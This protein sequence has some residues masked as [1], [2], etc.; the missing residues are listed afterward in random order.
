MLEQVLKSLQTLPHRLT[1]TENEK[2]ACEILKN[3][4]EELGYSVRVEGFSSPRTFSWSYLVIYLGFFLG[5]ILAIFYPIWGGAIFLISLFLFLGEQ[6]TLFPVLTCRV[7]ARG[8]SQNLIAFSPEQEGI[9]E[10]SKRLWL[11]AHYDSS[12]TSLAFAPNTVKYIRTMFL[13]SLFL[14]SLGGLMILLQLFSS[15]SSWAVPKILLAISGLYFFYMALMML[16]RELRGKPVPGACDNASGVA[17]VL[18]LARRFQEKPA[19]GLD[20]RVLLT[21]A[22]E[23]GMVGMAN[24]LKKHCSELERKKDY[25]FNFDSLGE[26]ELCYI[27]KEGMIFPLSGSAELLKIC[28]EISQQENFLSLKAKPYTALTLDTLVARSRGFGVLSLMALTEQGIPQPWH[29]FDDTWDKIDYKKL[30]LACDFAQQVI[31]GFARNQRD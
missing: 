31:Q 30:E 11:V 27:T 3:L 1:G 19:E 20:L 28:R 15:N 29:W 24:F 18:E 21:G 26:G 7:F 13:V 4:L 12:K 5:L 25:F 6:T 22:E 9:K 17:V 16:E 23:V 10:N 14:L 2:K 8:K